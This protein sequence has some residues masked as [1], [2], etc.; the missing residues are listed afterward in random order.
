MRDF[1]YGEKLP[2]GQFSD[3]PTNIGE[4]FVQPIRHVYVHDRCGVE[5]RMKGEGLAETYATNPG[6]Y[7]TTFCVGCRDYFPVTEFKWAADGVR[8]DEVKGEP[9]VVLD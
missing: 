1:D 2:N 9:G 8:L 5:T 3:H 4:Q 7:T 6:F